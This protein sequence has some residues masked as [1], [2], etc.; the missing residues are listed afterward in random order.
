M[1]RAEST[2]FL[3]VFRYFVRATGADGSRMLQPAGRPDAGFSQVG[4]PRL[5]IENASYKEGQMIYA[6]KQPGTASFE[7]ISM[8]RGITRGDTTFWG[9][10]QKTAEGSG[11]YRADLD[12]EV[13]HRAQALVRTTGDARNT[14]AIATDRPAVII[15]ILN[16][17]PNG[18]PLFGELDANSSEIAVQELGITLE[19]AWLEHVSAA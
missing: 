18:T 9:W 8:S 7:D 15:H 19:H 16:A 5:A 13:F 1:A 14:L 4:T 17:F 10:A 12:V 11:E 2:D 6:R 3:Q